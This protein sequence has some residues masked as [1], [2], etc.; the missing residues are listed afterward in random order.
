GARDRGGVPLRVRAAGARCARAVGA[1]PLRPG[2][3]RGPAAGLAR[4]RVLRCRPDH[5]ALRDR[6]RR[7]G[8]RHGPREPP[9]RARAADR[10]A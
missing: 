1:P 3:A 6:G 5:V 10:V 7:R 4:G 2:R 8:A 9:G